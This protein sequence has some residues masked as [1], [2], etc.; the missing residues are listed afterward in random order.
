MSCFTTVIPDATP[1]S[2]DSCCITFELCIDDCAKTVEDGLL[3]CN[4]TPCQEEKCYENPYVIGDV[5]TFQTQ[6]INNYTGLYSDWIEANIYDQDGT[7]IRAVDNVMVALGVR[8][9]MC[10]IDV[11]TIEV[12]TSDLTGCWYLE[13]TIGVGESLKEFCTPLFKEVEPCDDTVWVE[14]VNTTDCWNK[15]YVT[16]NFYQGTN[17]ITYSNGFRIF[18]KMVKGLGSVAKEVF[19]NEVAS[20]TVTGTDTLVMTEFTPPYV[21]RK[22]IKQVL[23]GDEVY[24]DGVEYSFDGDA[25]VVATLGTMTL[26]EFNLTDECTTQ[27][28]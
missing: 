4:W 16:P 19:N 20:K 14:S 7:L 21:G 26:L 18:A 15:C 11:Q 9:N 13:F 2:T 27:S 25:T 3:D 10:G 24:V 23:A 28:C 8:G 17:S 5:F 1:Q 12:D 6:E 22:L